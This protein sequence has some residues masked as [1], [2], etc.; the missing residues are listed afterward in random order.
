MDDNESATDC[1]P[2]GHSGPC[3]YF[4][5]RS[6]L[7]F[8]SLRADQPIASTKQALIVAVVLDDTEV[9]MG[10]DQKI[11]GTDSKSIMFKMHGADDGGDIGLIRSVFPTTEGEF[12]RTCGRDNDTIPMRKWAGDGD[13]HFPQD[14]GLGVWSSSYLLITS[15]YLDRALLFMPG[16]RW[17]QE[18]RLV[19]GT[20]APSRPLL[21]YSVVAHFILQTKLTMRREALRV[22][23]QSCRQSPRLPHTREA[24]LEKL[25]TA[26]TPSDRCEDILYRLGVDH[27]GVYVF[28]PPPTT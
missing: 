25:R 1:V 2:V 26:M 7:T 22:V 12:M 24:L 19:G 5:L 9:L 23:G 8:L 20:A 6:F 11:W 13:I 27:V 15:T 4:A 18:A 28:T 3:W 21:V 14:G 17:V 10:G 16:S